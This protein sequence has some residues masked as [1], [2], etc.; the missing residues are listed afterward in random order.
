MVVA[1]VASCAGLPAAELAGDGV[2]CAGVLRAAEVAAA[3]LDA[4]LPASPVVDGLVTAG[5]VTTPCSEGM[6]AV[7]AAPVVPPDCI[8]VAGTVVS[9]ALAASIL[10]CRSR[11]FS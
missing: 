7:V 9:A 3:W 11:S 6:P 8:A 5:L 4:T 10:A 1:A 2:V